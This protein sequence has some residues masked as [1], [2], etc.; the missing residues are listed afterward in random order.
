VLVPNGPLGARAAE[1]A[2]DPSGNPYLLEVPVGG[3]TIDGNVADVQAVDNLV[4]QSP[5]L[6]YLKS[7]AVTQ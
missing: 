2:T 3:A 4:G 7:V 5:E 1:D 6:L